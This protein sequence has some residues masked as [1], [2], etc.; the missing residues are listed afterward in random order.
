MRRMEHNMAKRFSGVPPDL[1]DTAPQLADFWLSVSPGPRMRWIHFW[2]AVVK[3]IGRDNAEQLSNDVAKRCAGVEVKV[4]TRPDRLWELITRRALQ[5]DDDY[6]F[7]AALGDADAADDDIGSG[8]GDGGGVDSTKSSKSHGGSRAG[9]GNAGAQQ[10]GNVGAADLHALF[11][12]CCARQQA[13]GRDQP[14]TL[15]DCLRIVA[16]AFDPS[17]VALS[18]RQQQRDL[19]ALLRPLR[20]D[21]SLPLAGYVVGTRMWLLEEYDR[22]LSEPPLA[23]SERQRLFVLRGA[24][25]IGKSTFAAALVRQRPDSIRAFH[26]CR[27]GS[28]RVRAARQWADPA[29]VVRSLA[30]QLAVAL[31]ALRPH[32][33]ALTS[34]ELSSIASL[35]ALFTRLLTAPLLAAAQSDKLPKAVVVLI[36]ALDYDASGDDG[37]SSSSQQLVR[38]IREQ[39]PQLPLNVRFLITSRESGSSSSSSVG[40]SLAEASNDSHGVELDAADAAGGNTSYSKHG[41]MDSGSSGSAASRRHGGARVRFAGCASDGVR[42]HVNDASAD[43]TQG[44]LNLALHKSSPGHADDLRRILRRPLAGKLPEK[45]LSEAVELLIQRSDGAFLHVEQIEEELQVRDRWTV[46]ELRACFKQQ[47]Y[48]S[49]AQ[50][51]EEELRAAAAPPADSWRKEYLETLQKR[52]LAAEAASASVLTSPRG[53]RK[54]AAA[55]ADPAAQMTAAQM[56]AAAAALQQEIDRL[57]RETQL[58]GQLRRLQLLLVAAQAP[59]LL[60]QLDLWMAGD[61]DKTVTKTSEL[62]PHIADLF[63]VRDQQLH[64]LHAAVSE[65][66]VVGESGGE[67][68][69]AGL[70]RAHVCIAQHALK[71]IAQCRQ[72]AS[73]GSNAALSDMQS[74]S[75][76]HVIAHLLQSG[77]GGGSSSSSSQSL[78]ELLGSVDFWR[79]VYVNGMGTDIVRDL[80]LLGSFAPSGSAVGVA[81]SD[82]TS[83]LLWCGAVLALHPEAALQLACDAPLESWVARQA[84]HQLRLAGDSRPHAALLNR[85][86]TWEQQLSARRPAPLNAPRRLILSLLHGGASS[87]QVI[88]TI[89]ADIGFVP[90]ASDLVIRLRCAEPAGRQQFATSSASKIPIIDVYAADGSTLLHSEPCHFLASVTTQDGSP[91]AGSPHPLSDV[92]KVRFGEP[93]EPTSDCISGCGEDDGRQRDCSLVLSGHRAAVTLVQFSPTGSVAAIA[94]SRS[95][96][97]MDAKTGQLLLLS[98]PADGVGGGSGSVSGAAATCMAFAGDGSLLAVGAADGSVSLF[99]AAASKLSASAP[100]SQPSRL[101][102]DG[103]AG[104]H[105]GAVVA[106]AFSVDSKALTSAGADSTVRTWDLRSREQLRVLSGREGGA[107]ALAYLPT[108]SEVVVA[109]SRNGV[110]AD[111]RDTVTGEVVRQLVGHRGPITKVV[112]GPPGTNVIATASWDRSAGLWHARTGE[113]LHLLGGGSGGLDLDALLG[114]RDGDKAEQGH[115]GPVTA[116]YFICGG[117]LL[118]TLSEG[119]RLLQGSSGATSSGQKVCIWECATGQQLPLRKGLPTQQLAFP[120]P[121]PPSRSYGTLRRTGSIVSDSPGAFQNLPPTPTSPTKTPRRSSGQPCGGTFLHCALQRDLYTAS[122]LPSASLVG[123]QV[124][125]ASKSPAGAHQTDGVSSGHSSRLAADFSDVFIPE[126]GWKLAAVYDYSAPQMLPGSPGAAAAA[127]SG[128]PAPWSDSATASSQDLQCGATNAAAGSSSSSSAGSHVCLAFVNSNGGVMLYRVDT[129]H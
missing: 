89:T 93:R 43:G 51:A 4:C 34:A 53:G 119:H 84:A 72:A 118:V 41:V 128:R 54:A 96:R 101:P 13:A 5:E 48:K 116:L 81:V 70:Q 87:R 28:G 55:A 47:Q 109:P 115:V 36:D 31:P 77:G 83:W 2:A 45:K 20:C 68:F 106:L 107:L 35:E 82:A 105:A 19:R 40:S 61:G 78:L 112:P 12:S 38:L 74:Y 22:W 23:G 127:S 42:H 69:E 57:E 33:L 123:Q 17:W 85:C 64:P 97:L 21:V 11:V 24:Q 100:L 3:H 29:A 16:A 94:D 99:E 111:V 39:L 56:E 125:S 62:L 104:A 79:L 108:G 91:I 8:G 129:S 120:A 103:H 122:V 63:Y 26:F 9:G 7:S 50:G 95:V 18:G 59:P 92:T 49:H 71:D 114:T 67:D 80:Q 90:A 37:T 73:D 60:S 14:Q 52:Q 126:P 27:R 88:A 121:A 25:G 32:L 75:L 113:L 58:R 76:R 117:K 86:E 46:E 1:A 6:F 30:Y 66:L 10:Q 124:A 102:A 110:D 98:E 65:H 44:P 15:L